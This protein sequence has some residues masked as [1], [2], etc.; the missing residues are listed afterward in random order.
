MSESSSS[1]AAVRA[2]LT[3]IVKAE[4]DRTD[5]GPIADTEEKRLL[6]RVMR[7]RAAIVGEIARVK[8]CMKAMVDG[9]E[10]MLVAVDQVYGDQCREVTAALIA[11]GKAR[12]LKT[13]YGVAGFRKQPQ[14]LVVEDE[15]AIIAA[16][17]EGTAPEDWVTT[18]TETSVARSKVKAK[19]EETGEIPPGCVVRPESDQF[20]MKHEGAGE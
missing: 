16:V 11:G 10:A 2:D 13:P 4:V 20:Y 5:A 18:K 14:A 12:S 17:L 9:L 6:Y 1:I 15:D 19:F 7:R 3:E 8:S